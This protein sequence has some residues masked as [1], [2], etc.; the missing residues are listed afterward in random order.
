MEDPNLY[1]DLISNSSFSK[2]DLI[3]I[4]E[5]KDLKREKKKIIFRLITKNLGCFY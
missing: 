2:I 5:N 1:I 4:I 3:Q